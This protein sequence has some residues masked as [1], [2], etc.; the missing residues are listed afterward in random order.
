[1]KKILCP[2]D[3]S[4]TAHGAIAYAAKLAKATGCALTLLHVRSIFHFSLAGITTNRH[5][6]AVKVAERLDEQCKEISQTFKISCNAEVVSKIG[7]LSSVINDTAK[8]FDLIVMG[9]N[10]ADDL[11]QFFGGSNTYNAIVKSKTP[12]LLIPA[13]YMYSEIKTMV[14][15]YDYLRERDL[16]LTMLVPFIKAVNCKLTVLQV[17]EE[18]YSKEAEDDLTDFEKFG[19]QNILNLI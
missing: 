17:M 9:S 12:L 18:A 7:K 13:G 4:E 19:L 15:A 2:T 3:F 6:S 14:Y 8:E 10:G 1:M 16:P 5:I 11:Y